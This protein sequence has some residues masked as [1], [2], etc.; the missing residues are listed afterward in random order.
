MVINPW[1]DKNNWNLDNGVNNAYGTYDVDRWKSS[2]LNDPNSMQSKM[3]SE[4]MKSFGLDKGV[5]AGNVSELTGLAGQGTIGNTASADTGLWGDFKSALGVDANIGKN[6]L[7]IGNQGLGLAQ[8]LDM[9]PMLE[10]Q[11]RL[12]DQQIANN[13]VE[14]EGRQKTRDVL[15]GRA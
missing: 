15:A 8:Y 11:G 3:L 7:V 6:L 12:L 2:L 13:R 14:M 10:K 4:Q 1:D 5:T 9:K